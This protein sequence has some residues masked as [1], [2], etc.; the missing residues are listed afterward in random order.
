MVSSTW[1]SASADLKKKQSE[2]FSKNKSIKH[3]QKNEYIKSK[4]CFAKLFRM[5]TVLLK[6]KFAAL[7]FSG[8]LKQTITCYSIIIYK[9]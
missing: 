8:Q 9:K 2:F 5:I 1:W 6:N 7:I 4:I 3:R